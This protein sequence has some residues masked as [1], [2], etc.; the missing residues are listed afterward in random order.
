MKKICFILISLFL[1]TVS[2]TAN[3]KNTEFALDENLK[4]STINK[5]LLK[6]EKT[7][8]SGD[9]TAEQLQEKSQDIAITRDKILSAKK[10]VEIELGFVQKRMDVLGPE[11]A[12]GQKEAVIIA[13][14]RQEFNKELVAYKAQLAEADILL[15]KL[16]EIDAIIINLKNKELLSNLTIKHDNIIF[17]SVFIN[18]SK[19]LAV[20]VADIF[21]SPV[22][23]YK[24][25]SQQQKFDAK[26]TMVPF[27]LFV[28]LSV[29]IG[30]YLR[31]FLMS[32]FGYNHEIESPRYGK[33]FIVGLVVVLA[34]GIIPALLIGGLLFW[35]KNSQ[36]MSFGLFGIVLSNFLLYFLFV[37]LAR[38]VARVVLTPYNEKWRLINISTEKSKKII[39]ALYF[40]ITL[41][42]IS[43]FLIA[44]A[45]AAEYPTALIF[46]LTTIDCIVK[47]ACIILVT[48]KCLWEDA[49]ISEE[50]SDEEEQNSTNNLVSV[51]FGVFV[52]ALSIMGIAVFGY[53][54][55]ADYILN[56]FLGSVASLVLFIML[57]KSF[58][59]GLHRL[60]LMR[61]WF[62]MFK[63]R[64]RLT[65]RIGLWLILILDP[66]LWIGFIFYI[67]S[68]WGVST[69]LLRRVLSKVV[70]GFNIGGVTVSL[71]SI[72]TGL[73]IFFIGVAIVS[74]LKKTLM[75]NVLSKMDIDDG[76]K[77]SLVSGV[78]FVGFIIAALL[79]ISAMG[80]DLNNIA[81]IAGA[82][83]FGVGLG[84]Q[85][86]VNNFVSGIILLFERP[87]KAGDWV[88]INGEEGII[89]QINI[90]TTE[91]ITW[92]KA[93]VIIPNA[94]LLANQVKNLTHN[95]TLGRVEIKVSVSYGSDVDKVTKILLD[96]VNSHKK[97]LK[98]PAAYVVFSDFGEDGLKFSMRYYLSNVMDKLDTESQIRYEINKRFNEE[99]ITIPFPQ[100]ELHITQEVIE[101]KKARKKKA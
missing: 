59:E 16:D 96:I 64:R 68:L 85:N 29:G 26:S 100:R 88:I 54:V 69:D 47:S 77:N 58:Q 87:V 67:L 38:A 34:Y 73:L 30:F 9:T 7:I 15:A 8:K 61:F 79:A 74:K 93:C 78:G 12:E 10:E 56:R 99:G 20:Y 81:I 31:R 80:G 98:K 13:Q 40:S 22:K 41:I 62:N 42:S 48:K 32:R 45:K 66:F 71:V 86:V 14:K 89:K 76:I 17:P 63:I 75:N 11:P 82:L 25:L 3:A 37:M 35:V 101:T 84:L 72:I 95:D 50:S 53:P 23:W 83:S 91:L 90:R 21:H 24:E 28:V 43:A 4:F 55:M 44:V 27:V 65:H 36:F 49:D 60:L 5:Q 18:H 1:I 2:V 19:Q 52:F 39:F 6:I 46:F 51:G 94:D 97:V 33:K 92:E 57:R 70:T